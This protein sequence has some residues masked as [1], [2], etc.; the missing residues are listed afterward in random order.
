MAIDCR[1]SESTEPLTAALNT[2]Q[3]PALGKAAVLR[4]KGACGHLPKGSDI[5]LE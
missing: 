2:L 4:K 3:N 1:E 5:N